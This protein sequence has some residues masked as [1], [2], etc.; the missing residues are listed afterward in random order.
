MPWNWELPEWPHFRYDAKEIAELEKEFL[1]GAGQLFAYLKAVGEKEYRQFIVEI[2]SSEGIESSRIEGEI[3]DRESFQSSIRKHFRLGGDLKKPGLKEARLAKLLCAVYDTFDEPLTHE[4]LT[5]WHKLL[6][7][8]S[9]A[10]DDL[11]KYRTHDEPM[12]IV[13]HRYS[14]NTVFFQA[15]PSK[16]IHE[17]MSSF[18][19]W[20]NSV[21]QN[22]S[23]LTRAALAHV[24]FESIHPFEDGNSRLGRILVEKVLSQGIG[25]PVLI[26]VSSQLEKQKKSY[27][28]E[29]GKCNRTLDI[30]SW[31]LFFSKVIVQANKE[32]INGLYFLIEKSK[33]LNELQEEINPRQE[34]ALLRM[35]AEGP[36]GF[37][38]G[39]SA[40]NYRAITKAS[41]ASA[42]RDLAD[43]VNKGALVK[44]GQLRHRRYFLNLINNN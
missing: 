32:A 36:S 23:I 3:L 16:N 11:G 37:K 19:D 18:I 26:A 12:Q 25:R 21:D 15:P 22:T 5:H 1:L 13:S 27:Y 2:L 14:D 41:S 30:G 6:F 38:G 35:F 43:L 29:L 33:I 34:K 24:Y 20:F 39:L 28:L 31:V 44:T 9:N 42:T 17:E 8:G 40:K 10:I 4:M 7:D